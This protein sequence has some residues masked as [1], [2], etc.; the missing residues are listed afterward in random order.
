MN[1]TT[2]RRALL[3][4]AL[5]GLVAGGVGHFSGEPGVAGHIWAAAAVP[6]VVALAISILRDVRMG[7]VGV[8]AIA[9]VSMSAALALGESLAAVVIAIMYSGGNAQ[10]CAARPEGLDRPH[11]A[12]CSPQ[13]G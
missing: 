1:E 4:L 13:G 10:P 2:Y 8:D 7:R 6:V 11:T 12:F 9:L 5:A 3:G